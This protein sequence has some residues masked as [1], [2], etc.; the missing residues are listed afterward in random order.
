MSTEKIKQQVGAVRWAD[1][2]INK[3]SR[4]KTAMSTEK[5]KQQVGAV[6]WAELTF[7][8]IILKHIFCRLAFLAVYPGVVSPRKP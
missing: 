7:Y 2:V 6:R 5:K 4:E 1:D 8:Y 3:Y